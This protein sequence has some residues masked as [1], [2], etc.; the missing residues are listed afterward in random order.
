MAHRTVA[1]IQ[2]R[3]GSTRLPGKVLMEIGGA[4]MLSRVVQRTQRASRIEGVIVATTVDPTDRL[5]VRECERIGV[6]VFCGDIWNVLDRY[7]QAARANHAEAI[8]RITADCPLID[9]AVIDR[10]VGEFFDMGQFDYASNTLPPR[11]FPRGLD[12]EIMTYPAL[13][14]SWL[15]DHDPVGREHIT[16]YIYHHPEKFKLHA[17]VNDQDYSRL[18]WTVDTI[19]DLAFVRTIYGHFGHDRFSWLDVLSVLEQHPQWVEIN[20]AVVQKQQP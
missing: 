16:P 9:A 12:V 1:I 11:T 5:V 2:A 19:E 3:M 17:V 8:V 4:T 6:S 18:R 15:E 13:E 7:Y 10:V 14:R 20:R